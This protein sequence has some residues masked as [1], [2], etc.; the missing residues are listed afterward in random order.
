MSYNDCSYVIAMP[1]IR[2]RPI[3]EYLIKVTKL[4]LTQRLD[5]R[6]SKSSLSYVFSG[7][8]PLIAR[9]IVR[10]ALYWRDSSFSCKEE[11]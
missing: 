5:L 9:V 7:D 2:R 4:F 8:V 10:Q 1:D 11:L 6:D 3:T